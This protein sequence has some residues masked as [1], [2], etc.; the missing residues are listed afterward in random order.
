MALSVSVTTSTTNNGSTVNSTEYIN[1]TN[2]NPLTGYTSTFD[3]FGYKFYYYLIPLTTGSTATITN[4]QSSSLNLNFVLIG[5]GGSG[6]PTS[7]GS[8]GEICTYANGRWSILFCIRRR[9][10][11]IGRNIYGGILLSI[12]ILLYIYYNHT[13]NLKKWEQIMIPLI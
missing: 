11:W 1:Y 13:I 3:D 9:T 7:N 8:D 4:T 5:N 6:G 12:L 10:K 2:Y